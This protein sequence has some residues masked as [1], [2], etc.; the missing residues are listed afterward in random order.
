MRRFQTEVMEGG[1][2]GRIHAPSMF[3]T[4]GRRVHGVTARSGSRGSGAGNARASDVAQRAG[5]LGPRARR[6]RMARVTGGSARRGRGVWLG[7][8]V[9]R[10]ECG[11]RGWPACAGISGVAQWGVAVGPGARV[12]GVAGRACRLLVPGR[13]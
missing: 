8:S 12:R 6:A 10:G 11:H 9:S 3:E 7:C 2:N 13:A 5:A 1:S 4:N